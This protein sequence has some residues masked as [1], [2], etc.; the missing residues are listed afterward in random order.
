M[1]IFFSNAD[2]KKSREV[3]PC[4]SERREGEREGEV[5]S[6]HPTTCLPLPHQVHMEAAYG[7]RETEAASGKAAC[8]GGHAIKAPTEEQH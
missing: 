4:E 5:A 3:W 2:F 6:C 1:G 7:T 8:L